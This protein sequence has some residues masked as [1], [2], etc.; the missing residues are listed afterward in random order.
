VLHSWSGIDASPHRRVTD[1][2]YASLCSMTASRQNKKS[3]NT[4]HLPKPSGNSSQEDA[5][6][7]SERWVVY[8][9]AVSVIVAVC[10]GLM[11]W[12]QLSEMRRASEIAEKAISSQM[13]QFQLDQ[14]AWITPQRFSYDTPECKCH[15]P[16]VHIELKNT[17]KVPTSYVDIIYSVVPTSD[18]EP[19]TEEVQEVLSDRYG[20]TSNR[21]RKE[22]ITPGETTS[23]VF[24]FDAKTMLT[25]DVW[26]NP[27]HLYF[28]ARLL[29]S[30]RSKIRHETDVCVHFEGNTPVSCDAFTDQ[31]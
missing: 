10:Q 22:P 25:P 2:P 14:R 9:T 18:H 6:R 27:Q 3:A 4:G 5:P 13:E 1:R 16:N 21:A 28:L 8:L 19:T 20:K 24:H 23:V 11:F 30:D 12:Y 15:G 7:W 31:L 29:Y 17:G 26:E